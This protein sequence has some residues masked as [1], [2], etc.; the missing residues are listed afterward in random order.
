MSHWILWSIEFAGLAALLALVGAAAGHSFRLRGSLV[1]VALFPVVAGTGVEQ[2]VRLTARAQELGTVERLVPGR[3]A[4]LVFREGYD[5]TDADGERRRE[6]MGWYLRLADSAPET[7]STVIEPF[8]TKGAN[9]AVVPHPDTPG[10]TI[11]AAVEGY[12][13][14]PLQICTGACRDLA[15]VPDALIGRRD[16]IVRA[17]WQR[18]Q[19]TPIGAPGLRRQTSFEPELAAAARLPLGSWA[20]SA[21]IAA[22]ALILLLW[23]ASRIPAARRPD[24]RR[25]AIRA[26]TRLGR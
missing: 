18:V 11:R 16:D 17:D 15:S 6:P 14:R 22:P 24:T 1:A 21:A 9:A 25:P 10:A 20:L 19:R 13:E 2:A 8:A 4:A 12:D 23:A 3:V 5:W 7:L 26:G